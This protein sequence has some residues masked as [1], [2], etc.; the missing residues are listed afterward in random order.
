MDRSA[1]SGGGRLGI[2]GEGNVVV[3]FSFNLV[4]AAAVTP[5]NVLTWKTVLVSLQTRVG[6]HYG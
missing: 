5:L 4:A 1:L 3:A 6:S 2:N